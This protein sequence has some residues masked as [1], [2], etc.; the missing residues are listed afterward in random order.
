MMVRCNRWTYK[1]PYHQIMMVISLKKSPT[2]MMIVLRHRR[3]HRAHHAHPNKINYSIM[4]KVFEINS[5]RIY[6]L[7]QY[8][9]RLVH[10]THRQPNWMKCFNQLCRLATFYHV[11]YVMRRLS[12]A[13]SDSIWIGTIRATV[14]FVQCCSVAAVLLT[15]IQCEIICA[16]STPCNG[17]KWK[18]CVRRAGH[19]AVP[20][21][22]NDRPIE[23]AF[24][25][26][27]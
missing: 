25:S 24:A 5:V 12:H 18:R 6:C 15:Q 23:N 20:P 11:R 10:G 9:C 1:Q 26:I 21:I 17:Q 8:Y 27:L 2:M 19:L 7:H 4:K 16:L 3:S 22:L 14:R 13:Y